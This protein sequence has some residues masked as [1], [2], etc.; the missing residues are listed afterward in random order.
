MKLRFAGLLV[1]IV[2]AGCSVDGSVRGTPAASF[3]EAAQTT[4]QVRLFVP[5]GDGLYEYSPGSPALRKTLPITSAALLADAKGN[6]YGQSFVATIHHGGTYIGVWAP[7]G[8]HYK[9][10]LHKGLQNFNTWAISLSGELY[11]DTESRP[12]SGQHTITAFAP[13]SDVASYAISQPGFPSSL[14]TDRQGN[15]YVS[16]WTQ[17]S[18]SGTAVVAVYEP[19][20]TTPFRTISA[21]VTF[22]QQM[23]F[24]SLGNLYVSNWGKPSTVAVYAPNESSPKY[25]IRAGTNCP[26]PAAVGKGEIYV[27]WSNNS[28]GTIEA[29]ATGSTTPQRTIHF[30][31]AN[32]SLLAVDP[33]GNLYVCCTKQNSIAVFRNGATLWYTFTPPSTLLV[34]ALVFARI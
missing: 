17:Q 23:Q 10:G 29:F 21:G 32:V 28:K 20:A 33:A 31:E 34:N 6:L 26:C 30:G 13:G 5:T 4:P 2:L 11:V 14:V 16:T 18:S 9:Y 24:D 22:P 19:G 3:T 8:S 15:L 1:M 25:V 7:G 12:G 27:A